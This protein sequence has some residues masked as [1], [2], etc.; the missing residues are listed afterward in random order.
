MVHKYHNYKVLDYNKM[1]YTH[2]NVQIDYRFIKR[3]YFNEI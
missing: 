2:Y 3:R 1:Y